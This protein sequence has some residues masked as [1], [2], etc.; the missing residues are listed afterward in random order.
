[1][2]L[3]TMS[4]RNN[5]FAKRQREQALKDRARDKE[6][7]RA[8]RKADVRVT[9]GPQIDWSQA[10]PFAPF[11]EVQPPAPAPTPTPSEQGEQGKPGEPG[12]PAASD[13]TD[14]A[15]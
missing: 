11:G 5:T 3:V 2:K 9:K 6:A 8:A 14:P 4:N 7:R 1:M 12:K 13:P 10:A 15:E